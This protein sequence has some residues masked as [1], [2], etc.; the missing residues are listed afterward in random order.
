VAGAVTF[1]AFLTLF[2]FAFF[3]GALGAGAA[4]VSTGGLISVSRS[5]R[6][7]TADVVSGVVFVVSSA[8]MIDLLLI[9]D[10]MMIV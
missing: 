10:V 9:F 7:G 8:D 5:T 4:A 1:F 3:T 2:F 6:S